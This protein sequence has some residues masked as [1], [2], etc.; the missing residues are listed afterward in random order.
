MTGKS[1][2]LG[3]RRLP[4][5]FVL[6][7]QISRSGT[8]LASP[9]PTSTYMYLAHG[10]QIHLTGPTSYLQYRYMP[11]YL[12]HVLH[13]A[14]WYSSVSQIDCQYAI[15]LSISA[16]PTIALPCYDT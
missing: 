9:V 10:P 4:V 14:M 16:R 7:R 8:R 11:I 3:G 2:V 5:V 15:Q 6:T 1:V 12:L 13:N